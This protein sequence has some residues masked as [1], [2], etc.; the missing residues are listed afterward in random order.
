MTLFVVLVWVF[1]FNVDIKE[2]ISVKR[3]QGR[4]QMMG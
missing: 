1:F 3:I 2:R 4:L